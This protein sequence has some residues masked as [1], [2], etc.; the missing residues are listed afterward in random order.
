MPE[1]E[2]KKGGLFDRLRGAALDAGLLVETNED[3]SRQKTES[4]ATPVAASAPTATIS[5]S[6]AAPTNIN[7]R[8]VEQLREVAFAPA[9][10]PLTNSF[11][12]SLKKAEAIE[13]DRAKAIKMALM[14][15]EIPVT[16][17]VKEIENAIAANLAGHKHSFAAEVTTKRTGIDA[18]FT[19]RQATLE[20]AISEDQAR[21]EEIRLRLTK[22]TT[23]LSRLAGE[24][25][26]EV[27]VVDRTESEA[28]ASLAVVE[29]EIQTL[30]N[31]L[32]AA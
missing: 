8:L 16:D 7:P 6:S 4:I 21:A 23:D 17:L 30:L 19:E 5:T 25:A 26:G 29:A 31:G 27:S 20:T 15:S 28:N 13:T 14:F 2:G 24:K 9:N 3:A 22:N 10:S 11:M 1:D 12:R 18:R 32:K